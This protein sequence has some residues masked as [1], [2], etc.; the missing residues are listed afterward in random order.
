MAIAQS[1]EGCILTDGSF[2]K[3]TIDGLAKPASPK[4]AILNPLDHSAMVIAE[5]RKAGAQRKVILKVGVEI[6]AAGFL[7]L[8]INRQWDCANISGGCRMPL[9]DDTDSLPSLL[10]VFFAFSCHS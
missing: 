5:R 8:R 10:S 6:K 3:A 9:R 7:P 4:D 1:P 2:G